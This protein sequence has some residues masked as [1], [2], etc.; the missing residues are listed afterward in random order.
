VKFTREG[1]VA[2][3]VTTLEADPTHARLRFEVEDTGIGIR[4][5]HLERIFRPFEQAEDVQRRFGGTGLGLAISRQLVILMGSDIHVESRVGAGSRFWFE[6]DLPVARQGLFEKVSAIEGI[7]GYEGRRRKV[8]V[9]DDIDANRAPVVEFLGSLGF[10][11]LEADSGDTGV[12]SVETALPDLVLM[13]SVMPVMD[14][15]EAIRR[16]RS[17]DAFHDLPIIVVSANAS[18]ADRQSSLAAGANAFLP[19]PLDFE[20]LLSEIAGLLGLKWI[21]RSV[22]A[23]P[24]EVDASAPLVAP[25]PDE[26]EALLRLAR[27]G[28]MRS[29]RNHAERMATRD[30]RLRPLAT[31]LSRL[32]EG[33]QSVAIVDLL[34]TLQEGAPSEGAESGDVSQR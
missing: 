3:R 14:G 29:I 10:D 21:Q 33:F 24:E 6:L 2:L 17:T 32:A 31:R 25:P 22:P 23:A 26:M 1:K 13:D 34:R 30:E 7:T 20:R 27:I 19:K 12:R 15:M 28:N 11:M 5:E 8:L 16:L 9:V 18:G 4:A